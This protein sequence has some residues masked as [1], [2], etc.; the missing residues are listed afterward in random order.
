MPSLV[1]RLI[2]LKASDVMTRNL[3]TLKGSDSISSA[4]ATLERHQITG[5]PVVEEGNRLIGILSLWDVVRRQGA[6]GTTVVDCMSPTVVGVSPDQLLV[7]VARKMCIAHWHRVPVVSS[8]GRLV[9]L[10][11]TMDVLA[12]L[13]NMFDELG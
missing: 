11:S 9:G 3:V 10:I 6:V 4:V 12:A 7:E 8:E 5:A 2:N 1:T 13:V